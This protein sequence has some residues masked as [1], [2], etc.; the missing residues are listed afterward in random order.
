MH[1]NCCLKVFNFKTIDQKYQILLSVL[2]HKFLFPHA[3]ICSDTPDLA[4]QNQKQKR[5][6]YHFPL[7]KATAAQAQNAVLLQ[8]PALITLM[9]SPPLCK[10]KSQM[11]SSG[12]FSR[13]LMDGIAGKGRVQQVDVDK[14]V[15]AFK[16][17]E[18]QWCVFECC[19]PFAVC[20]LSCVCSH[21][22]SYIKRCI[23]LPYR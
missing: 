18:K 5:Q 1:L 8:H 7:T 6:R 11:E 9:P 14:V 17:Q 15:F 12:T 21:I 10:R 16:Y 2:L 13:G 20:R 4:D 3:Q 19:L 23:C 22:G